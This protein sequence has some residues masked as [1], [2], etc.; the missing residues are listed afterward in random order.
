MFRKDIFGKLPFMTNPQV[1]AADTIGVLLKSLEQK[2]Q[3]AVKDPAA[4]A[5]AM[6]NNSRCMF[7]SEPVCEP[8]SVSHECSLMQLHQRFK[9]FL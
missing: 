2:I 8:A 4:V 9:L 6:M 7:F 1:F 5:L 3:A